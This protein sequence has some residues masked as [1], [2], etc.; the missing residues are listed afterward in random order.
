MIIIVIEL[1][2]IHES[3]KLCWKLRVFPEP[4]DGIRLKYG[5]LLSL[6]EHP[7]Q[8][9]CLFSLFPSLF[10]HIPQLH[11]SLHSPLAGA[12]GLEVQC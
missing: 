5:A 11:A 4:L 8:G 6:A 7:K 9:R 12:Q 3:I 2:I 10:P 1:L